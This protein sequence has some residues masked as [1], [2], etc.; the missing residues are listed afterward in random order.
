MNKIPVVCENSVYWRAFKEDT[1]NDEE[2]KLVGAWAI[3]KDNDRYFYVPLNDKY[4]LA[5]LVIK[6]AIIYN[7]FPDDEFMMVLCSRFRDTEP[8]I[9]EIWN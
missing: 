4:K 5:G 7:C 1:I 3:Q 9:E 8:N 2:W 6:K